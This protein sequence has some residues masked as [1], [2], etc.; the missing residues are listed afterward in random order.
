MSDTGNSGYFCFIFSGM[1][2]AAS[3]IISIFRSTA[4]LIISDDRNASKSIPAV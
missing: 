1:Y 2:L 3:P 4:S